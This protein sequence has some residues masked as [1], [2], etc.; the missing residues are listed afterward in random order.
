MFLQGVVYF[1]LVLVAEYGLFRRLWTS[2][3]QNKPTAIGSQIN[4]QDVHQDSDVA[5]EE[6]RVTETPMESLHE[7]DSLILKVIRCADFKQM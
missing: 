2:V 7:T 3:F 4:I 1:A 5:E 6:K